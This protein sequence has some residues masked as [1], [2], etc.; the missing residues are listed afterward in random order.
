MHKASKIASFQNLCNISRK[1]GRDEANFLHAD[2]HQTFQKDDANN[3]GGQG[4]S[5]TKY[6]KWQVSKIFAMPQK[7][8]E[9]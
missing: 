2:K 5:C 9:G 3:F 4:K 8:S 6:P 7:I 1:K